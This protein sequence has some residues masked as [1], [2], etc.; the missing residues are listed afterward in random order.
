MSG[1]P[2]KY[3]SRQVDSALR[4]H[5]PS[6]SAGRLQVESGGREE[7]PAFYH[8]DREHF[9]YYVIEFIA[10]GSAH[11]QLG[12]KSW[13]LHPGSIYAYDRNLPHRLSASSENGMTKYFL[14]LKGSGTRQLLSRHG[15][16]PGHVLK[17]RDA[18]AIIDI[19]DDLVAA[20]RA[21]R[22]G[23]MTDCL[24]IFRH[25]LLKIEESAVSNR[26]VSSGAYST[27]RRCRD[28]MAKHFRETR[29]IAEVARGC[30]VDQAYLSRLFKKF[31]TEAPYHFL[32][33]LRMDYASQMLASSSVSAKALAEE[34]GFADPAAFSRSFK[35]TV[36]TTPNASRQVPG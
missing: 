23:R 19:F 17:V 8:V 31:D 7:C 9:P 15:I 2:P 10:R 16:R 14:I 3:F 34:L 33:R 30:G 25:L 24:A 20:G 32:N 22:R 18:R 21:N 13:T 6:R 28:Y 5:L 29:S 4:F 12:T 27:Y 35:R 26:H 1:K 36:G 11:I